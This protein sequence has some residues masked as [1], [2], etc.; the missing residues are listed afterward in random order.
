MLTRLPV[1]LLLAASCAQFCYSQATAGG[2]FTDRSGKPIP[3]ARLYL[4]EVAEDANILHATV[5]LTDYT[6]TTDANG[7]FEFKNF[8][9][10][11]YTILYVLPGGP[12][13][14]PARMSIKSLSAVETSPMPLMKGVELGGKEPDR[15][16]GNLYTLLK[17]HT[18]LAQGPHMKI[19]NTTVR[20]GRAG[21][22]FEMRKGVIWLDRLGDKSQIKF[23][24]WTAR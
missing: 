16:W 9:P 4:A 5:K 3:K 7:R 12:S 17:G 19:W 23:Q 14:V 22:Y 1:C 11:V 8:K 13:V 10:G 24:A 2:T 6:A 18:F 21:P 20:R 15:A